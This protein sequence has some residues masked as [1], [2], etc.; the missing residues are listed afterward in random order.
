[1]PTEQFAMPLVDAE[2]ADLLQGEAYLSMVMSSIEK[3][4]ER[5]WGSFF[6]MSLTS[7]TSNLSL[8]KA[9]TDALIRAH[10][11]GVTVKMILSEFESGD[12]EF[13]INQVAFAYL[14]HAGIEVRQFHSSYR[15]TSHCKDWIFDRDWQIAGS[16]NLSSG[17]LF[18][19]MET[20]L[21]IQSNELN[22]MLSSRF[23]G[24]WEASSPIENEEDHGIDSI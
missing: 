10:Q 8:I 18:N 13:D 22:Q 15:S 17:G 9:L 23:S 19:N 12:L 16:G 6:I 24:I 5:I 14:E 3:A 4:R 7:Q 1:M 11:R 21:A 2:R 20:A